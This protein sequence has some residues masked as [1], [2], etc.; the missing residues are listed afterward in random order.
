MED[1]IAS[2]SDRT[3][4]LKFYGRKCPDL[5]QRILSPLDRCV[6][7]DLSHVCI[8]AVLMVRYDS[9]LNHK[10][11]YRL[12]PDIFDR[13]LHPAWVAPIADRKQA[14]ECY[15]RC[16]GQMENSYSPV[17]SLRSMISISCKSLKCVPDRMEMRLGV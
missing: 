4:L 17:G 10:C 8:T 13:N 5:L 11:P 16:D 9:N 7:T 1:S 2:S 3:V 15:L 12:L 14:I 6:H